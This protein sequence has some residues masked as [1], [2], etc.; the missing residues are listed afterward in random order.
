MKIKY[1]IGTVKIAIAILLWLFLANIVTY[2]FGLYHYYKFV[3]KFI[4][5]CDEE[6]IVKDFCNKLNLNCEGD[7]REGIHLGSTVSARTYNNKGELLSFDLSCTSKRVIYYSNHHTVDKREEL[8]P[9]NRNQAIQIMENLRKQLELPEYLALDYLTKID[10]YSMWKV[11]YIWMHGQYKYEMGYTTIG[12][13]YYTGELSLYIA[14]YEEPHGDPFI[15]PTK[16][17]IT[18]E[19]S[20]DL[21]YKVFRK[22]IISNAKNIYTIDSVYILIGYIGNY[23]EKRLKPSWE[24]TF[25][26]DKKYIE[27][28]KLKGDNIPNRNI[29]EEVVIK[30][31]AYTGA[32][33]WEK[34]NVFAGVDD[35]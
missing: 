18:R 15:S 28:A 14:G 9:I 26:L 16:F 6:R 33:S 8:P 27:S 21:A 25:L 12:I 5:W 13:S 17:K 34:S 35:Y 4:Y 24:I 1:L 23:N 2:P 3:H 11:K 20:I 29:P 22:D 10:R 30:V 32:V 31:N 7:V 19:Q